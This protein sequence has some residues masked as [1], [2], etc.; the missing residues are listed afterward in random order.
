MSN[1]EITR[2]KA[3][4]RIPIIRFKVHP[5]TLDGGKKVE[6]GGNWKQWDLGSEMQR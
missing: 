2:R 3:K 1:H 5:W 6:E 4:L